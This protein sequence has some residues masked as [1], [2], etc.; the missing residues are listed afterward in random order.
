M[1]TENALVERTVNPVTTAEISDESLI[2]LRDILGLRDHTP[3]E[4]MLFAMTANRLGL[5]PFAR[6]IYSVKRQDRRSGRARQT[7]QTSID[8]ARGIAER[9]GNYAG[10][11]APEFGPTKNGYPEYARVTVL[12]LIGGQIVGTTRDAFWSEYAPSDPGSGAGLWKRMPRVMLAKCAE[13]QAL[14]AAFP[15]ALSGIYSAEEMDQAGPPPDIRFVDADTGEVSATPPPTLRELA[16]AAADAAES[17]QEAPQAPEEDEVA[18]DTGT[19]FGDAPEPLSTSE[20]RALVEAA[21][22][23][24]RTVKSTAKRLYPDATSSNDL[25]DAQRGRLWVVLATE[26]E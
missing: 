19:L 5:D 22:L 8:G 21:K 4:L 1:T 15:L 3:A 23:D 10:S 25:T 12:K 24:L 18:Q 14:R 9:T 26:A 2:A 17:P 13:M 6:Q 20:F 7:I 11:P 16:E